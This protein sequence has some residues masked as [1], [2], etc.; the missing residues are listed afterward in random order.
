MDVSLTH[1]RLQSVVRPGSK[2]W[3]GL[4]VAVVPRSFARGCESTA[5]TFKGTHPRHGAF[6]VHKRHVVDGH[7]AIETRTNRFENQL[8][9]T[10]RRGGGVSFKDLQKFSNTE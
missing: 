6:A 9:N 10:S 7:V 2:R 5:L 8:E 1:G 4:S 3:V